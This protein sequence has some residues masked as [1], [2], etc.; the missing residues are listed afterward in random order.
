MSINQSAFKV[1]H[2]SLID[3]SAIFNKTT[4]GQRYKAD[5]G[6]DMHQRASGSV[7]TMMLLWMKP[8]R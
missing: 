3:L 7:L 2:I 1:E 5:K 4:K 8:L 6:D